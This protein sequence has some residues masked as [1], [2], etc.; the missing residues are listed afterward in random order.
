V[1]QAWLL[2]VTSIGFEVIGSTFLKLSE[3]L[4][5][6]LYAALMF[7]CYAV[8]FSLFALALKRIELGTAYAVWAGLGTVLVFLV[9]V[10]FFREG[11]TLLKLASVGLIIAGVI[12]LHLAQSPATSTG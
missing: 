4:A 9:G 12:G 6:P 1:L 5:R 10:V 2:L 7:L 8:A 3:G 11:V